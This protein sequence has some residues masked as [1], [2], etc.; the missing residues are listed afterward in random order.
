MKARKIDF[1]GEGR[2]LARFLMIVLGAV[3][4]PH[5]SASGICLVNGTN[6]YGDA[7]LASTPIIACGNLTGFQTNFASALLPGGTASFAPNPLPSP[8]SLLTGGTIQYSDPAGG[9]ALA[10]A[11]LGAGTLG[12]S[13]TGISPLTGATE[14]V[15]ILLDSVTFHISDGA[16]FVPIT[17]NIGLG[18][19]LSGSGF[20]S[21]GFALSFGGQLQYTMQNGAFSIPNGGDQGWVG[22][23]GSLTSESVTGFHFSGVL[24]VTNGESL[25]LTM[26]LT[27]GCS[28]GETCDFSH[29][30]ALS[31]VLPS[32]VTFTSDSGVLL[33][34]T[35]GSSVPEPSSY[36]LVLTTLLALGGG[37]KRK[38]F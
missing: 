19:N 32:D 37:L 25:P 27:L 1:W 3:L 4:A 34:Q 5:A 24:D 33:T 29:T 20:Y 14:A 15:S 13:A 2:T 30:A 31:F 26:S 17:V 6:I 22:G 10:T 23:P 36:G 8:I 12:D 21:N 35:A 11:S 18:G 16:A 7:T 9:V 28:S 38:F